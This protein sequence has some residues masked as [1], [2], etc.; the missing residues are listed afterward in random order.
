MP[1]MKELEAARR[2]LG[3]LDL[4][5]TESVVSGELSRLIGTTHPDDHLVRELQLTRSDARHR[6]SAAALLSDSPELA[7]P[8]ARA[9]RSGEVTLKA[10]SRV[11]VELSELD[12]RAERTAADIAAEVLS[13]CAACGP[14]G[15]P[16]L[17][18]KLVKLENRRYPRDV[19]SARKARRVTVGKQ[20]AQGGAA[21]SAYLDA[22]TLALL[23]SWLLTHGVKKGS[24]DDGRTPPQ[25]NADALDLALRTAHGATPRAPGKAMCTVVAVLNKE[26][27]AA[28]TGH[29]D[30]RLHPT[31]VTTRTGA[32][33]DVGLADLLRLGIADDMYAAII[34][35]TEEIVDC[36]LKLGR[37]RRAA[38]FDQRIAL[39]LLDG[40]CQHPGCT[41][42][43]DACDAHHITAWL[44]GG[45]TD[46][47]NLTLLCRRHHSDNDDSRAHPNRGHMTNR[48]AHPRGR[49]GWAQPVGPDGTRKVEYNNAHRV[50]SGTA[51]EDS[52]TISGF[53]DTAVDATR[54]A[55]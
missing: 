40:G 7:A 4:R 45:A 41:R 17:A 30:G 33:V 55:A 52:T 21:V 29:G 3:V 36:R 50:H 47:D 2:G 48:S 20:D 13:R 10:L 46:V 23:E 15:A 32:G 18:K 24:R 12:D 38:S 44:Q 51:V 9:L 53:P 31:R 54:G 8:A 42:P 25:R 6:L 26:D 39:Q 37:T 16:S 14:H 28:A 49:T 43:P 34:D 27:L 22:S 1:Q 5:V 19:D 11:K 35:P